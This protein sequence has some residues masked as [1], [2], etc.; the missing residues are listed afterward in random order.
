MS[1][2][3]MIEQYMCAKR[4]TAKRAGVRLLQGSN[5]WMFESQD[6]NGKWE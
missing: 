3:W 6:F 1:R 4:R 2:R 5:S